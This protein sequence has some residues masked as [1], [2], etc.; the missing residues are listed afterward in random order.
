MF[1]LFSMKTMNNIEFTDNPA[2]RGK[3]NSYI[4][5]SV[6]APDVIKSWKS[7]L[8]SFEWITAEYK[9]KPFEDLPEKEQEKR[10][11]V[12]ARLQAGK[13]VEMPILGI[14]MLDNVEIGSGRA[15]FLT[16]VANGV[17]EIP[18]HIPVT[19]KDDFKPFC[20]VME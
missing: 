13:P 18:V 17:E 5:V 20:D 8:F 1:H 10:R 6:K 15:V 16:L 2:I 9:I 12:E 14:G 11:E 19:Y 3:E 7:S 4:T